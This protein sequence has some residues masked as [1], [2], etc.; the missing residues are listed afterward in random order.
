[1]VCPGFHGR[2]TANG[3]RFN[4]YA[5]TAAHPSLPFGSIVEITNTKTE[6][7]VQVRINDRGPFIKRR[8]ID[9]SYAAAKSIGIDGVAS[10]EVR[11]LKGHNAKARSTQS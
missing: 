7:S 6:K 4:K 3:E 8:I 10:V 5:M 1:M 9:L 2:K 11:V